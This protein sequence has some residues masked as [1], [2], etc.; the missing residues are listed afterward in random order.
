MTIEKRALREGREVYAHIVE[1]GFIGAITDSALLQSFK[2]PDG[3]APFGL[4]VFARMDN[5]DPGPKDCVL[6]AA[7]DK[8]K[9]NPRTY[10]GVEYGHNLLQLM[11]AVAS[12]TFYR[13][14]F[15]PNAADSINV[16]AVPFTGGIGEIQSYDKP[17]GDKTTVLAD[18]NLLA[19]RT[20]MVSAIQMR[21]LE[22]EFEKHCKPTKPA[23]TMPRSTPPI[24]L[25]R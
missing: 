19:E 12:G 13:P 18:G 11:P 10:E 5:P 25:E 21:E 22:K 20:E 2:D 3:F 23:P 4:L 7:Q 24:G 16:I 14:I 17:S 1:H 15:C 6:I 9:R 8:K